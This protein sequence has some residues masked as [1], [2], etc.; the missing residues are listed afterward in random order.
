MNHLKKIKT[1]YVIFLIY[2]G[3]AVFEGLRTKS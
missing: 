3:I 2:A 1:G